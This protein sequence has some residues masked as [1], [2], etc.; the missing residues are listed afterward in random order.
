MMDFRTRDSLLGKYLSTFGLESFE[1]DGVSRISQ[2][3]PW[4]PNKHGAFSPDAFSAWAAQHRQAA[5]EAAT[6]ARQQEIDRAARHEQDAA[7]AEQFRFLEST[8]SA[9]N[10]AIAVLVRRLLRAN[11]RLEQRLR[12]AGL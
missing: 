3:T 12:E 11:A 2:D 7:E 1:E 6:I 5:N 9:G 8:W 4:D 10:T